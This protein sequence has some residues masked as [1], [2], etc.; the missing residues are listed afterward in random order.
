MAT[1]RASPATKDAV[2]NSGFIFSNILSAS[3]PSGVSAG[4]SASALTAAVSAEALVPA[5]TPEGKEALKMLLKMK[6][7]FA[8]ASFVAGLARDVAMDIE[9][10]DAILYK[11]GLSH[12]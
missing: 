2:A 8:T 5:L 10:L 6:P 11:H 4:T 7:E 1:S 3:L 12:A 9:T